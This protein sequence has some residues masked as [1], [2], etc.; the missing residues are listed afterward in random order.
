[1]TRERVCASLSESLLAVLFYASNNKCQ[2]KI[3]FVLTR[4]D[5]TAVSAETAAAAAAVPDR[6]PARPAGAIKM[7]YKK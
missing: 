2:L 6:Q 7:C 1:M 5:A 3:I 4:S